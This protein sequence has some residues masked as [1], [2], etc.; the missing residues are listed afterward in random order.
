MS[1]FTNTIETQE[2]D[3]FEEKDH[4]V[5]ELL[6]DKE[7]WGFVQNLIAKY[8]VTADSAG[9]AIIK[10][11]DILEKLSIYGEVNL[12]ELLTVR[13]IHVKSEEEFGGVEGA[14]VDIHGGAFIRKGLVIGGSL[15][16]AET[17]PSLVPEGFVVTFDDDGN[18]V[19]SGVPISDLV[20]ESTG[21]VIEADLTLNGSLIIGQELVEFN[22]NVT[23]AIT[24][25]DKTID[26]HLNLIY[27]M[28]EGSKTIKGEIDVIHDG[29]SICPD[30]EYSIVTDDIDT[31]SFIFS[32][33]GNDIRLSL[34]GTGPGNP[35]TFKYNINQ[36]TLI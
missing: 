19:N 36:K 21:G 12:Q 16:F 22:D 1:S 25:G 31:I 32:F 18:V 28:S 2:V 20:R 35:V 11:L 5:F 29:V 23:Q 15:R 4:T 34:V 17:S 8:F 26:E 27:T 6:Y 30:H 9:K 10:N 14:A 33:V 13:K 24:I 7:G 3:S